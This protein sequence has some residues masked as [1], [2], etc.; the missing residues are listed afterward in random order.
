MKLTTFILLV[1][2]MHIS[3]NGLSQN[4]TLAVT[5]IS[6]QRVLKQ[7][8]R[9]TGVSIIYNES[10][11]DDSDRVTLHV[12]NMPIED[13]L[14]LCL[15][16]NDYSYVIENGMIIIRKDKD[17][18]SGQQD[19]T[20]KGKI[21]DS[22]GKPLPG[23]TI[24]VVGTTR[25]VITDIDGTY[26]IEANP[27]D[28][29]VFSFIGMESQ[30]VDVGNQKTINVQMKDK[31]QELEDVTVV[32]FGKQKKE[33][34]IGS[35]S[36][37]KPAELKVPSSN[38]TTALSGR[39]AGIISYQRSG[40]PGQDNADFFVRG[41]T[42][43][44]TNTNPL[45]LI[46]GIELSSTDLAR[47]QPDDI[48]SF[49]IMKDATATALYGARGANGVILVTTKQGIEGPAKISVRL[50]NSF[51]MPTTDIEFADP[52]TY[53]KLHNEAILT[54]DP[55]GTLLYSQEKIENTEAGMNPVIYPANDWKEMLF[56]NYT[57]NQRAN[58]SVT[59]GGGVARYYVAAAFN[60]DNGILKVD[61]RNNFNNNIAINNYTLRA[62]VNID[63]FK[64][65]EMIVRLHGNFED[66]SGPISGGA[67]MYRLMVHSNPVLFPA[68]FPIDE[69]HRY[70]KH[71][72]FG[73]YENSYT[74]PY[75]EM[76]KGYKDKS[77]SQM[78]A[79]VELKQDLSALTK[80]LSVRGMVNITRLAQFSV[81]RA[82]NPFFYQIGSYSRQTGDYSLTQ[83]NVGTEY[84]G[85]S[86]VADDRVMNST[87]YFE[88]M[89]NYDRDF[90][91]KH[92]VSGLLVF[93]ARQSMNANTGSLQLS[94]PSRNLGLSGRM[95]YSYDRRY[96]AEFNFGY[97]GSERFDAEHRF[98]F[99]PF[100]GSCLEHFQRKFL[101]TN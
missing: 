100:S 20:V 98:G 92:S 57:T 77:R 95:T 85:Y 34:V 3:A 76:V 24:T 54:R 5:N 42:T 10:Y 68:Y 99:F 94:L 51:S 19:K 37:V 78:L 88:G 81:T 87:F 96:F 47:L 13:V 9:Q 86:E 35:I 45:I 28:K 84:L 29:L 18:Q 62:N 61:K 93:M 14:N 52:V 97:N 74:N 70:V 30:I 23:A 60:R 71:I 63:I 40:E 73:N 15:E 6:V 67:E 12:D 55:G 90:S 2:T 43:F 69:E 17:L 41:I 36:T 91:E 83:T 59:G 89:A 66:Y 56:K 26:S 64:T 25:G 46:D 75:A 82:Y 31:S 79:Q 1:F 27:T 53:M 8:S 33:S 49:S 65:T 48:A 16:G 32:A 4:V 50:E 72:M 11:F 101:E 21:T 38:L 22:E 80:G 58:L 39:I 7:I 44:G